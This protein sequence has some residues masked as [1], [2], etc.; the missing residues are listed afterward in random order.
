MKLQYQ[1]NAAFTALLMIILAVS[2][3]IIY[4]LILDLLI[5]DEERQLEQKGALIVRILNEE[6]RPEDIAK[7]STYLQDQN[8]QLF[9]YDRNKNIVLHAS[10]PSEVTNGFIQK[11]DFS[12]DEKGLWEI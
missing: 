12:N 10:L 11:N 2:G 1:L 5:Q 9:L 7:F 3:Y 4:A 6:R 8:L